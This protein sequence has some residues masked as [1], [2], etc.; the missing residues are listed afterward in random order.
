M[1]H[2]PRGIEII[3][4]RRTDASRTFYSARQV[5]VDR[6]VL[7]VG[8]APGVLSHS[9]LTR[10]LKEE[11]R[12]LADLDHP[13]ILRLYDLIEQ[14]ED[15]WLVVEDVDGP[16][17]EELIP[18]RLSAEAVAALGLD[19]CR[20]LRHAHS[21]GHYHGALTKQ[22]VQFSRS[23]HTKLSGFGRN[24]NQQFDAVELLDTEARGGV[25]PE[26]SIGQPHSALSDIFTLGATLYE[27]ASGRAPF[28]DIAAID[29]PSRVR[30]VPHEP[31]I[32]VAPH[33]PNALSALIEQMLDKLPARRPATAASMID[34]L[35]GLIGSS[36]ALILAQELSRLGL[37]DS[38]DLGAPVARPAPPSSLK[39]PRSLWIKLGAG[40]AV[41]VGLFSAVFAFQTAPASKPVAWSQAPLLDQEKALHL[42]VVASPWAHV[43]VDGV[44]RETT[45][46]A[47]PITLS[48]GSHV[49]RLEHPN[50]PAEE[51]TIS[52]QGGQVI[53]LNVQMHVKV[54]L[55]SSIVVS[56]V[57][58]SSP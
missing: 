54:E 51:R 35:E 3:K 10:L 37:G 24:L 41:A 36:T 11:A 58:E 45:P 47:H 5:Q 42:R 14:D 17:L 40:A 13:N 31:L 2:A 29:Y 8:L 50:A 44:L 21:K 49:V 19:L 25:S 22:V 7:L 56:D 23:G 16:C 38:L 18:R 20:A 1:A 55:P 6:A 48:P 12:V 4:L 43:L 32:K 28:G 33:L 26:T 34:Q 9:P 27:A 30:N 15:L 57:D 52:G 53:L 46:F 39:R